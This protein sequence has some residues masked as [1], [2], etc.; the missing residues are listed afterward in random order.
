MMPPWYVERG[1][2]RFILCCTRML[3]IPLLVRTL[4][5]AGSS[6]QR[7]RARGRNCTRLLSSRVCDVFL[8]RL[9][10]CL[11]IVDVALY[12]VYTD[13]AMGDK[14]FNVARELCCSSLDTQVSF[15]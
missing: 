11:I 1:A 7:L 2:Y 3:A 13:A 5:I 15:L 6:Q 4:A 14:L 12:T 9:L 8:H 10:G